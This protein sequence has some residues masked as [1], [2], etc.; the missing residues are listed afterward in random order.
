ME[1][2]IYRI[3][4]DNSKYDGKYIIRLQVYDKGLFWWFW[5]TVNQVEGKWSLMLNRRNLWQ[6]VFDIPDVLIIDKSDN[7]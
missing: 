7:L 6:Q 3:I 5:M 1:N 2:K 4:I